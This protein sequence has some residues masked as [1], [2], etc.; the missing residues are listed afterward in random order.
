MLQLLGWEFLDSEALHVR[1]HEYD[2]VPMRRLSVRLLLL[3]FPYQERLDILRILQKDAKFST[4]AFKT[5]K[6]RFFVSRS[7]LQLQLNASNPL[8]PWPNGV[9]SRRKFKTWI[10][11]RL[12]LAR[13]YMY[14]RWLGMTWAHFGRDQIYTQ[15]KASFSPLGHPIQVKASWMTPIY[16]LL[17]NEKGYSAFKCFFFLFC[18]LRVLARKLASPFGHP[19]QVTKQ[20]ELASTCDY[21]QVR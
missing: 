8:K 13:P 15:I 20:V 6:N 19:M 1:H 2:R 9:A 21:L 12:C 16:L 3:G 11:L 17:P 10:D 7:L 5:N 14:L 18:D 4:R